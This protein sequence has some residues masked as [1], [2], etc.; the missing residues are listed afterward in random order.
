MTRCSQ[1]GKFVAEVGGVDEEYIPG[2]R[3]R[4]SLAT[5]TDLPSAR[6]HDVPDATNRGQAPSMTNAT[7]TTYGSRHGRQPRTNKATDCCGGE[8]SQSR[9]SS[10]GTHQ[11]PTCVDG[12][13]DLMALRKATDMK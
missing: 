2:G 12:S 11:A 1:S 13:F 3:K 10:S 8:S 5:A 6:W 4:T 7:F 9:A